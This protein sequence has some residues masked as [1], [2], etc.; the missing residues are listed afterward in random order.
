MG[1]GALSTDFLMEL[2]NVKT[3]MWD[4]WVAALWQEKLT[5]TG[6]WKTVYD[7]DAMLWDFASMFDF[8]LILKG[9]QKLRISLG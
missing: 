3:G 5:F 9:I 1:L 6:W 7:P 4:R 2:T 8:T